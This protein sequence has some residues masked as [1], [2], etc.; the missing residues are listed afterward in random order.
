VSSKTL[1]G[2]RVPRRRRTRAVISTAAAMV[3][4]GGIAGPA[5]AA[6]SEPPVPPHSIISFPERDFVSAEGYNPGQDV[7]VKVIRNAVTIGTSNWQA[8][9]DGLV[10]VNHPGGGC[11]EGTTPDILPGDKIQIETG[12]DQGDATTTANVRAEPAVLDANGDVVV[13]GTAFEQDGVTPLPLDSIE[14][15]IIAGN[16]GFSNGRRR[17]QA[18]TAGPPA[19]DAEL[20]A[21][22]AAGPGHWIVT[23]NNITDADKALAVD[24]ETRVLW[25]GADPLAGSELTIFEVGP[26][27]AIV[28][29]PSA[30]CTAPFAQT[31]IGGLSRTVINRATA[32]E[33]ITVSGPAA[34]DI[35]DVTVSVNGTPV[36]G[37]ATFA[38][39]APTRTW[40]KTIDGAMI[41]ALADGAVT[42]TAHFVGGAAPPPDAVRTLAKD[43]V[44]PPAPTMTPGAGT[45][46]SAQS[47]TLNN[48]EAGVAMRYTN[49]GSTPTASSVLFTGPIPVTASQTIKAIAVDAAGNAS[50]VATFAYTIAPATVP[51]GGGGGGVVQ[52]QPQVIPGPTQTIIIQRPAVGVQ[53][54]TTTGAAPRLGLQ[55]LLPVGRL[56]RAKLR[57]QGLR[58]RMQLEDG[59]RVV[60]IR[61]FRAKRNGQRTGRPVFVTVRRVTASTSRITLRDRAVRRLKAGRY[62]AE[63]RPGHNGADTSGVS[64]RVGFSVR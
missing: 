1:I 4:A 35:T 27:D 62:V 38:G 63:I 9:A 28:G 53:G 54:T 40:S 21:D 64:S 7:V 44:A 58:L 24:S 15:R 29:G 51:Q 50:A 3:V 59:T 47:V 20:K 37:G 42:L 31:A 11:W 60:R 33:P 22:T 52:P 30:P 19:D 17:L 55:D 56:T 49:D 45:F 8:D 5:N 25:L 46:T 26:G 32:A 14:Q 6:I 18:T 34:G 61:I 43:T 48:A 23:Y 10:E 39:S 12:V 36:A 16:P 41:A 13:R 2:G 57:A